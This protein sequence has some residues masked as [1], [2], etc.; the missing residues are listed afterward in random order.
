MK[1]VASPLIKGIGFDATC[2]LVAVDDSGDPVT[3]SPTHDD[4]R[5]V[6]LWQDHRAIKEA[7]EIN[8]G[9][10]PV[11]GCVGGVMSPEMEPPKLLWL[12]KNL[13]DECWKR[14]GHFF[15]L[16]DYLTYRATGSTVRSV[17]IIIN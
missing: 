10:H 9:K 8:A 1:G 2:S 13:Y 17:L 5:N 7:E 12:R 3:I 4:D 14:A 16:A 6:V 15:D 11:L